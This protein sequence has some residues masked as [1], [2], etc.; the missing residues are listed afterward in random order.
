MITSKLTKKLD[1]PT[2][3][4]LR[5]TFNLFWGLREKTSCLPKW[6]APFVCAARRAGFR[7]AI[8]ETKV[9]KYLL[10]AEE[11]TQKGKENREGNDGTS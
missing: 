8:P 3:T 7:W 4:P 10:L 5:K 1:S 9:R 6:G 2:I 11:L